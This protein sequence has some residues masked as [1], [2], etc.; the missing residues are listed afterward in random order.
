MGA[1][2]LLSRDQFNS[3]AD[4]AALYLESLAKD[5]NIKELLSSGQSINGSR[6]EGDGHQHQ[7]EVYQR[8]GELFA[9][10]PG[11]TEERVNFIMLCMRLDA[12]VF[13][14]GLI[15][16][17][18]AIVL[19]H[20]KNFASARYHFLHSSSISWRECSQMLIEYQV[21]QASP[22][23]VDLFITQFVLQVLC[24]KPRDFVPGDMSSL[25]E[26]VNRDDG[27]SF[28]F[29]VLT[30]SQQHSLAN[31]TLQAYAS[32]HPKISK[33][34]PPFQFPLLNFCWFL[35]MSVTAG[36]V[37]LF[38]I[39]TDLYSP[40]LARDEEYRK[41]L[42]RDRTNLLWNSCSYCKTWRRRTLWELI[43]VIDGD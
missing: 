18:L 33:D 16:H 6:D 10:I 27:G 32:K 19:F 12:N 3:G 20:E 30:R 36:E 39:L 26:A 2:L 31:K 9:R 14:M 43:A 37:A 8:M 29:P 38:Q 28:P 5:P 7:P 4:L 42:R 22:L 1:I 13:D 17:N 21:S 25:R 34:C 24:V 41:Y 35:L 15:H 40:S 11:N 23:E